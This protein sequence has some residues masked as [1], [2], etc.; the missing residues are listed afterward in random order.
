MTKL[1]PAKIAALRAMPF[2]ANMWGGDV[3]NRHKIIGTTE[4]WKALVR[5]GLAAVEKE[6]M[7]WTPSCWYFTYT[8]T[9]KGDE[10]LKAMEKAK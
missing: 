10:A 6:Q 1:S 2:E 7:M 9:P 3:L 8:L 5:D 4:T